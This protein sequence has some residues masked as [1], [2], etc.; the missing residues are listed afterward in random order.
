SED[1]AKGFVKKVEKRI[2]NCPDANLSAEVDQ[3]RSIESGETR[4]TAWRVG[5][6]VNKKS[7]V[8][9]RMAIVRQGADVA[10]VTFTPAGRY[11]ISQKDFADLVTRAAQRLVYLEQRGG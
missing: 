8:F 4:G 10:Q 6:E 1:D 7:R 5:L 9:Y 3:T 11:D 2:A